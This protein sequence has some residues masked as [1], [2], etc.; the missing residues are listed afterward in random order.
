MFFTAIWWLYVY[1]QVFGLVS[2]NYI[3]AELGTGIGIRC[4]L[5]LLTLRQVVSTFKISLEQQSFF[6]QQADII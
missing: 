1:L 5:A 2:Y 6:W 4:V 3:C